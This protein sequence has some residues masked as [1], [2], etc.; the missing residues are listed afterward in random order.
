MKKDGEKY[1]PRGENHPTAKLW[2]LYKDGEFIGTYKSLVPIAEMLNKTRV[3][4]WQ[5]ATGQIAGQNFGHPKKTRDGYEILRHG[6]PY[7]W[8]KET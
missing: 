7:G 8:W 1:V 5:L 6:D 2:D 3:Y 4:C